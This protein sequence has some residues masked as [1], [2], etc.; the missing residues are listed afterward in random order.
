[1]RSVDTLV[2]VRSARWAR[3]G[4]ATGAIAEAN[5]TAEVR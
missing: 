5:P 4:G 2:K 1:M 3:S